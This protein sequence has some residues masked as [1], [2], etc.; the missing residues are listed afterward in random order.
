VTIELASIP[1]F[2]AAEALDVAERLY[3]ICGDVACLPSERDQNFL[4]SGSEGNDNEND[5][6]S[7]GAGRCGSRFVLKFANA[8]DG[9]PL[10]D[11]QNQAMRRA[12]ESGADCRVPRVLRSLLGREIESAGNPR[13]GVVHRVRVLTWIEGRV[14][15]QWD[16]RDA[17]LLQSIGTALAKIDLALR[18]FTH[19]AMHRK[20]QWDLR[21]APLAQEHLGL[22]PG[23]K[24]AQIERHLERWQGID[25]DALRHGVIHG[26]ANDHNVLIGGGRMTGLLDFGD[27][28][29]TATVCELAIALAYAMLGQ[30]RPI[31]AAAPLLRAYHRVLPLTEAEQ[32]ALPVLLLSRLSMSVCYSAHNRARNPH[33]P[34]QVVSEAGA[35]DLL[36]RLE[37]LAADGSLAWSLR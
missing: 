33:D 12:D 8:E 30:R 29:F 28:A 13:T 15:A 21:Q 31:D 22:L 27:M 6:G 34:Y 32:L 10:L 26:D 4:I 5:D 3:G 2:S 7:G 19:P 11:F 25:W 17:P 23:S 35:W 1:S 36:E 16:A 18:D 9:P 37:P 14:L 24:R 20:L